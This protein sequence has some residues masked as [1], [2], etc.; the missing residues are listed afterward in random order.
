MCYFLIFKWICSDFFVLKLFLG[1]FGS[2]GLI[3]QLFGIV[4]FPVLLSSWALHPWGEHGV[5]VGEAEV[6]F[7]AG[8]RGPEVLV[9]FYLLPVIGLGCFGAPSIFDALILKHLEA[10]ATTWRSPGLAPAPKQ[11]LGDPQWL[12]QHCFMRKKNKGKQ[13]INPVAANTMTTLYKPKKKQKP[14][15]NK[16]EQD[17]EKSLAPDPLVVFFSP[18]CPQ[19]RECRADLFGWRQGR[20]HCCSREV[21][22][23]GVWVFFKCT[24]FFCSFTQ[25]TD[26]ISKVAKLPTWPKEGGSVGQAVWVG[27]LS[28]SLGGFI[29]MNIGSGAN[30]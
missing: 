21:L 29:K 23:A 3:E 17:R 5:C 10:M 28:Y 9:I 26:P 7:L 1:C 20:K 19:R 12:C 11:R 13:V 16:T 24:G 18:G 15:K 4:H 2:F 27:Y 14:T 8:T 25:M 30:K 6:G 22:G